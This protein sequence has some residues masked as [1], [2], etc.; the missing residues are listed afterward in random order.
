MLFLIILGCKDEFLLNSNEYTPILVIDGLISNENPPY[1]V[2][3]YTCSPLNTLEKFPF[4][5]CMVIL[6]ENTDN[7][8]IL[9]EI[10]PGTYRSDNNGIKATIGNAYSISIST[11]DGKEYKTEPQIIKQPV[12]ID[13][14]FA[15]LKY[16]EIFG[17]PF[18]LPGYQFY[19]SSKIAQDPNSYILWNMIE[20]YQYHA[21]FELYAVFNGDSMLFVNLNEL[22]E[23]ENLYRCWK[24]QNS[25][26]F[27]TGKLA[28]LTSPI[29]TNQP[30]HF[31]GTD[32][33]KLQERYSLL[34]NQY[35]INKEAYYFWESVEDQISQENFLVSNQPYNI[36]GNLKNINNPE[37]ITYGYFTVASID[38]KRI[39]V[40]RPYTAF[41]YQIC[42]P[43]IGEVGFGPPVF[44]GTDVSGN[45]G[46]L[47]Q[48]CIDCTSKGGIT[49]K[50]DFWID[51]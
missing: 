2:N 9:S 38:Q 18:G 5:G 35:T 1:T 8:E 27:I 43:V 15:E 45:S 47:H 41:Y 22:P 24:T 25:G 37:E 10:D 44:Y 29:I 19:T 6:C 42:T 51:F 23:Y 31:V 16:K 40:N 12:E 48:S 20:T 50:P 21:D 39:Y 4:E 7:T 33:R 14:L 26:S 46:A 13:T 49:T 36:I 17:Y 30:L 28:N 32:S 11:P 3:L 34:L